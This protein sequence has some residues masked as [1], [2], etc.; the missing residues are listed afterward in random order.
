LQAKV[1]DLETQ[2][3]QKPKE[4]VKEVVVYRDQEINLE[5]AVKVIIQYI[6]NLWTGISIPQK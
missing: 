4:V 3:A 6:K 2:L 1:S 5:I